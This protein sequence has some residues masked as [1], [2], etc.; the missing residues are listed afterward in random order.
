M[1][2]CTARGWGSW[3]A[4]PG[5]LPPN[6]WCP[7]ADPSWH[8]RETQTVLQS[9]PPRFPRR[10]QQGH[11]LLF[12]PVLIILPFGPGS[13]CVQAVQS[14]LPVPPHSLFT[15]TLGGLAGLPPMIT[16][17]RAPRGDLTSSGGRWYGAALLNWFGVELWG[18]EGTEAGKGSVS[19]RYTSPGG[20]S[21]EPPTLVVSAHD[22]R[23]G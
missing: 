20:H 14:A 5:L 23:G 21:R 12:F 2:G 11:G 13:C 3:G 18:R 15:G 10:P 8:K 22:P 17:D 6:L 19:F 1:E 4:S 9:G 7:H 16:G